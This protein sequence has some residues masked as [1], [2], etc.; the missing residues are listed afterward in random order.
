MKI[1]FVTQW[2]DPEPTFKG[3][4]YARELINLGHEVEVLTGFPNYP[5]GN[6]YDGYRVRFLQKEIMEG[7][8]VTRVPLYPSHD[9]SSL[10]RIANY[11][12]FALSSA[13]MGPILAKKAD[14]IWVC[15]PPATI[16]LAAMTISTLRR[17]PFVY[18]I[19][20]LWP[21][22]LSATGMF[23]NKAGLAIVGKWCDLI[24]RRAVKIIVIS[25][26]FKKKLIERGVPEDK[27]EI[28]YN[29]T[30]DCIVPEGRSEEMA[31]KYNMAGKFNILFAGPMGKA[32][33]LESVLDAA[34]MLDGNQNKAFF[35]FM[36]G[37]IEV[38]HL[39]ATASDMGLGNVQFLPRVD[40]SEIG[41]YLALA[42]VLLVHLRDDPLF[43]ITIPGKTQGSMASGK[44]ILMAVE[45]DA[46]ELISNAKAGVTCTPQ[47]PKSIAGAVK[48]LMR[49]PRD[50]LEQLGKNG[51]S[52]FD[53]ELCLKLG[54][55]K[56]E[57][58]L[59]AAVEEWRG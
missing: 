40:K 38:N 7:V 36:G 30:Y 28:I 44:P 4:P 23:Q 42:D 14:V 35:T 51:R 17:T 53:N 33:A 11:C 1:L 52:Y 50:E 9:R 15:H 24:Y 29:W 22:T 20:D 6:I 56:S 46:A 37:G 13:L 57:A 49:L 10:G 43:R 48:Q 41:K 58:V 5:G 18:E 55:R 3:L 26:G 25:P 16:G 32:Q 19:Q 12:S 2:F 31:I 39:K 59:K 21:D 54:V 8:S 27:I 34:K 45:G 47:D